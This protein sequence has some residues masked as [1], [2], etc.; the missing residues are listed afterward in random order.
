MM[1]LKIKKIENNKRQEQIEYKRFKII[2]I[3]MKKIKLYK[4]RIICKKYL[5]MKTLI[6][7]IIKKIVI[8]F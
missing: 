8:I 6:V 7:L 3:N 1:R 5:L 4:S 2:S